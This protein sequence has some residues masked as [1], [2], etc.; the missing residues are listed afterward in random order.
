M[1]IEQK[2]QISAVGLKIN[3][4]KTKFICSE[5]VPHGCIVVRPVKSMRKSICF[6][7]ADDE[8]VSRHGS[9]N[10]VENKIIVFITIKKS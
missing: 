2:N 4:M 9:G 7:R 5:D 10:L 1:L 6:L 3:H 8:S